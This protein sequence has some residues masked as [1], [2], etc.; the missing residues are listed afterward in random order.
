MFL[1]I[2]K[3]S[4]YL[5][6][7]NKDKLPVFKRHDFINKNIHILAMAP[8]CTLMMIL[9]LIPKSIFGI[10]GLLIPFLSVLAPLGVG[11]YTKKIKEKTEKKLEDKYINFFKNEENLLVLYKELGKD[12]DISAEASF[13]YEFKNLLDCMEEDNFNFSLNYTL[14][15]WMDRKNQALLKR[16]KEQ[17]YQNFIDKVSQKEELA[18]YEDYL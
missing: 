12:K 6:Y 11:I 15:K 17:R 9:L 1:N 2:L 14:K 10:G 18:A 4:G 16:K 8:A 13:T 3:E 5:D 7:L